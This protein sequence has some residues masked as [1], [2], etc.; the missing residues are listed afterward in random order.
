MV[1]DCFDFKYF[2]KMV[3]PEI[4]KMKSI[5]LYY[6]SNLYILGSL[7]YYWYNSSFS[8][9]IAI[10]FLISFLMISFRKN[11]FW[12]IYWN[13]LFLIANTYIVIALLFEILIKSMETKSFYIGLVYIMLNIIMSV[14]NILISK[15]RVTQV[16]GIRN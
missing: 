13:C 15:H 7:I 9:P 5:V 6:L 4:V 8:N 11:Y 2:T 3:I 10:L 16:S 1:S 14:V 12:Q